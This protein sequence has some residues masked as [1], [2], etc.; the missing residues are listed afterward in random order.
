[1]IV[2]NDY[3][4]HQ[5]VITIV[6][7]LALVLA[8]CSSAPPRR[9]YQPPVSSQYKDWTIRVTPSRLEDLWRA[10][11]RVWP[12]EIRPE[13]HPGISVSFNGTAADR[14]AVEQAATAAAQRYIDSSMSTR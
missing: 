12:P 3:R 14:S 6:A 4:G 13:A 10:D 8:A 2:I 9:V 1:M 11:V 7:I 5:I